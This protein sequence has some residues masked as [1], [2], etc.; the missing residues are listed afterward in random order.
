MLYHAK[1][2]AY[3]IIVADTQENR[4]KEWQRIT[5]F[6]FYFQ[7]SVVNVPKWKDVF[8]D[9]WKAPQSNR[10]TYFGFF[11]FQWRQDWERY[12]EVLRG[13][14]RIFVAAVLQSL[15]LNRAP[16]ETINWAEQVAKSDFQWIIPC[17]FDAPV[18][19]NSQQFRQAFSFLE[20]YPSGVYLIVIIILYRMMI[21]RY[22]EI[23][24]RS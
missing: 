4:R 12:Y 7:P 16:Q 19:A 8:T 10:K 21:F 5:L 15:I 6:A 20:K 22:C 24:I 2:K 14:G 17:H 9:A 13:H 3:D 18:K 23:L 11:P 1:D